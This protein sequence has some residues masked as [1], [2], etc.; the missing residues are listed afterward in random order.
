MGATVRAAL[1]RRVLGN[2]VPVA[3]RTQV[4]ALVE[5]A[6]GAVPAHQTIFV[7]IAARRNRE[8]EG[9]HRTGDRFTRLV[10]IDVR[11]PDATYR[12]NMGSG[13]RSPLYSKARQDWGFTSHPTPPAPRGTNEF[14]GITAKPSVKPPLPF[15]SGRLNVEA[16]ARARLGCESE[17]TPQ[18]SQV[19][20]PVPFELQNA[21]HSSFRFN[22]SPHAAK[23]T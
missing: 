13:Q 20:Q 21:L 23:S 7:V 22:L 18:S 16:M 9:A 6:V 17:M 8:A 1:R 11:V 14:A 5:V 4:P 3:H 12:C 19:A 15:G 2:A 10:L